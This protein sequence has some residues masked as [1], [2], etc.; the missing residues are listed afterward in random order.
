MKIKAA[1]CTHIGMRRS[2]NQ[3]SYLLLPEC[4][5]F[6]VADGM[7][8]HNGGEMASA[9]AVQTIRDYFDAQTV[10]STK[11]ASPVRSA[12]SSANKAIQLKGSQD[13]TLQGMGTTTT[14]LH[15]DG[16]NLWIGH[17]GDSR[18]YLLQ[19]GKIWQLTRDH[20]VVQEKLRA[21]MITRDQLKTDRMRNVITRSVGF[22]ADVE[23][24]VYNYQPQKGDVFVVCSDGLSGMVPDEDI[25][26]IVD[27]AIFQNAKAKEVSEPCEEAAAKEL[28]DA[29]NRNGGDDNVTAIVV[30]CTG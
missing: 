13:P 28:I 20:S 24:D 18:T 9:M 16:Q 4:G 14:A 6:A 10:V 15:F 21:G 3:D 1:G 29:A 19:P 23:V 5:V 17:V 25:L 7:G 22:E 12:I 27:G 2:Q 11:E 8:G 26:Q 30:Q